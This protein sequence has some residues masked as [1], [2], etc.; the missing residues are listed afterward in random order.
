M[1][2]NLI[3]VASAETGEKAGLFESLGI[4]WKMFALQSVAFLILL[5]LLSRYV[6]PILVKSIDEREEKIAEG[7]KAAT[8]AAQQAEKAKDDINDLLK[9]ARKEASE[10]VTTAKEQAEQLAA[11]S[12]KKSKE[13][14]ERI[15][16]AAQED[17]TKEVASAKKALY[18]ETV[19]LV[20]FATEK[21]TTAKVS[22]SV[23]NETISA[24][25]KEA[26]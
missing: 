5:W 10:I 17:I 24:A 21:V 25:I 1:L 9:K 14:A 3:Y 26:K 13:R 6:Y 15:V 18:N 22:K 23:D 11:D 12:D 16:A 7:Q 8:E 19:D 2:E 4:D 20:A